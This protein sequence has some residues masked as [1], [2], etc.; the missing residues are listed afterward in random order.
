MVQGQ[1]C[2][3]GER[4]QVGADR[5]GKG[6][7]ALAALA[8]A[9]LVPAGVAIAQILAWRLA[10]F[11][12]PPFL[13]AA[14]SGAVVALFAVLG[15]LPAHLGL[16]PDPANVR[17]LQ[18]L[19]RTQGEL[20]RLLDRALEL[21]RRCSQGLA[22]LPREP[23]REHLAETISSIG[24]E[25]AQG[26]ERLVQLEPLW[27]QVGGDDTDQ[28]IA[29][30]T[31]AK[32]S[33]SDP[34]ARTQLAVALESHLRERDQASELLRRRERIVARLEAEVALLGSAN[35]ALVQAR[36]GEAQVGGATLG[37]LAQRLSTGLRQEHEAAALADARA[38]AQAADVT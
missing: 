22:A 30:L 35:L 24:G 15:S 16:K 1:V 32:E 27:A 10:D 38:H 12:T 20:R 4:G 17:L 28:E 33:A 37:A 25:I 21:Y 18:L 6:S 2:D 11:D 14:F 31:R 13:V 8:T 23:S 19:P 5:P 29:R 7:F 3:R 9:L 26:F 36:T 34:V